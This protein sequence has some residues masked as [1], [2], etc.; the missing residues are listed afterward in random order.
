MTVELRLC[1]CQRLGIGVARHGQAQYKHRPTLWLV[2]AGDLSLMF[3]HHA[4][5]CT[6]PQTRAFADRLCSIERI[7]DPMRLFYARP[8]IGKL[9]HYFFPLMLGIDAKPSSARFLERIQR[10][11]DDLD[12]SLE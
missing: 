9:H 4:I 6:Q 2:L 1:C 7:E 5:Y 10:V 11:F 8:A 3:L 12:E